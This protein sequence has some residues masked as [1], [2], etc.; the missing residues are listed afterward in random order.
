MKKIIILTSI[1]L[2]TASLAMAQREGTTRFSIGP[3]LGVAASNPLDYIP[4]D[5]GW[6]LGLG[7]SMEGEHFFRENVSGVFYL[8]F[9]SYAGRSTGANIKNKAYNVVPI[10]VGANVYAGSRFHFG[11]QIGAGINSMG[12]KNVT[13]FA[14][15]PQLGYN[16]SRNDKPLD[17]TFK[18]DGYA[19]KNSFS[20]IGLR[21]SFIL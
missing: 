9:I 1:A 14:Y 5:K 11:A 21:L 6:G 15:T 19:A 7:A 17:L 2:T 16:F 10:R 4:E 13:T 3:E 18:Y 12:G 20:A 8:G